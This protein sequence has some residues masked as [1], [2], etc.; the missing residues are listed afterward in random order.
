VTVAEEG[1]VL[2]T[3]LILGVPQD[4]RLALQRRQIAHHLSRSRYVMHI[5]AILLAGCNVCAL[6]CCRV[7][8]T[9]RFQACLIQG[10]TRTS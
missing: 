8:A 10:W 6:L 3:I 1:H 4:E 2:H 9:P 5:N 7:G